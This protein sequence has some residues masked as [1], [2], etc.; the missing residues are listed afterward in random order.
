MDAGPPL[1]PVVVAQRYK[2]TVGQAQ[3]GPA[4]A[5]ADS[6]FKGDATFDSDIA[7]LWHI[8]PPQGDSGGG[9]ALGSRASSESG[10]E[11]PQNTSTS[12]QA[13]RPGKRT[14]SSQ[15]SVAGASQASS[16]ASRISSALSAFEGFK[17]PKPPPSV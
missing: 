17:K 1:P 12:S 2:P 11:I 16:K 13:E 9:L 15:A 3:A 14:A 7:Q 8:T 5:W 4:E 6:D 10:W